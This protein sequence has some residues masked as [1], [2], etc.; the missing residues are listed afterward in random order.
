MIGKRIAL[1][2]GCLFALASIHLAFAQS[3]TGTISGNI[4]DSSGAPVASAKVIATEVSTNVARTVQSATDGSYQMLF[5]PIGK[6][7]VEVNVTGFKKFEQTGVVLEVNRNARVDAALQ[8]GTLSETMEV[9]SD[10]AMV[11]TT[12]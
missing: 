8:V 3:T 5:L 2:L 7:K 1:L 10:A 11:E 12:V 6:Y 4:T 9:K